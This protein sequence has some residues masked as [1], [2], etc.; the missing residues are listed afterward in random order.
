[1]G[2][3]PV[4]CPIRACP[5]GAARLLLWRGTEPRQS[6]PFRDLR[7]VAGRRP[8][9]LTDRRSPRVPASTKRDFGMFPSP[10]SKHAFRR[11]TAYSL[12]VRPADTANE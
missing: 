1:M 5:P 7:A 11:G 6:E 2:R 12:A 10:L 8:S 4:F 9:H 3:E